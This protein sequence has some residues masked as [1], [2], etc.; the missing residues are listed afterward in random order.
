M[1]TDAIINH[2]DKICFTIKGLWDP[3][4]RWLCFFEVNNDN[5]IQR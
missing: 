1:P 4:T 3:N 2:K 5:V